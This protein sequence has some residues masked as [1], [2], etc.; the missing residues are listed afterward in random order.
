MDKV[1]TPRGLVRYST[2]HAMR[3]GWDM[4]RVRARILRPRVLVY[5][6]LLFLIVT[7]FFA[8]LALRTPLKLDVIRDRGSM[9]REVEDGLIENVYRLQIMNTAEVPRHLRIVV[10]GLDG[11]TLATPDTVDVDG[12]ASRAVPVR[13]RAPA[14]GAKP[15]SN[16]ISFELQSQDGDRLDV[17]EKAVFIVPR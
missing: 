17:R 1:G 9:G 5:S 7:A 16:K 6:G 11:I 2:D 12:T 4:A 13:V 14:A 8:S 10:H 15:G 3:Q